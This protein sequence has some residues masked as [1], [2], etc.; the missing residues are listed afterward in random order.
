M[1]IVQLELSSSFDVDFFRRKRSNY[2]DSIFVEKNIDMIESFEIDRFINKRQ[3]KRRE[4]EYLIRWRKYESKFDDWRNL[5]KLDNIANLIRDYEN[6]MRATTILLDKR[7]FVNSFNQQII[8]QN[9]I[10]KQSFVVIISKRKFSTNSSFIV[11][12]SISQ[13]FFIVIENFLTKLLIIV[14]SFVVAL[15]FI[16]VKLIDVSTS[17]FLI[18]WKSFAN[19]LFV[20]NSIFVSFIN[21]KYFL[22]SFVNKLLDDFKSTLESKA[23]IRRFA[24]LQKKN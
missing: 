18:S 3:I 7:K 14:K 16:I 23:L 2:L 6:V 5:S 8:S 17:T 20:I 9:L 21:I 15:S 1:S 4:F 11:V 13:K 19:V 10:D 12:F 24:R 22:K